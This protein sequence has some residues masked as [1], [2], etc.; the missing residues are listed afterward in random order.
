MTA[1]TQELQRARRIIE[2]MMDATHDVGLLEVMDGL[3]GYGIDL[4]SSEVEEIM[5]DIKYTAQA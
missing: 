4:P 3:F 5:T 1:T 2:V